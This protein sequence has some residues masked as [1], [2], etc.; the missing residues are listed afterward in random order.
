MPAVDHRDTSSIAVVGAGPAGLA[1]ALVLA[2]QGLGVSLIG[3]PANPSDTRTT[4]LLDGSLEILR[5]AG[6][7]V[8]ASG[9][10]APLRVM[11]IVDATQ[12]LIRARAVAF[13]AAEIGL[14]AFGWNIP[15]VD[16]NDLLEAA[17]SAQTGLS[18]LRT[19]VEE[20]T[21][22]PVGATLRLAEGAPLRCGLVIAADGRNSQL[23]RAAGID[24]EAKTYP[25]T[26][27][28][29]NL[30][31]ARPHD[32]RSTEFHTEEGPFTLVPLPGRRVSLVWVMSPD[33]A[34]RRASL[35]DEALAAE[36]ERQCGSMLG[37]MVID[38]P[39][40]LWPMLRQ[41][42]TSLVGP[43]LA[44]VGEAGH[45]L[46]PIGAQGLNL[47]MRDIAAL[48]AAT[49]GAVDPGSPEVLE[50][51]RRD[52]RVDVASRGT[53]VDLLNRSLLSPVLAAQGARSIGLYLLEQ[54]GPLRRAVMREGLAG[55]RR[56]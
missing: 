12:R 8:A 1:A 20:M 27:L 48:A 28:T 53:A 19:N 21:T 3:P 29:L 6:V 2:R 36:I 38:S 10:A 44:L 55:G 52:R 43:R 24:V 7:D 11:S 13:Q 33:A 15:N 51:Y 23:R 46:P 34:D 37:R 5:R 47:T 26:A 16:L 25:Q 30:R 40:S 39:R 35:D 4:A 41:S 56:A 22:D 14:E 9:K 42:A 31:T 32:D 18:R 17:V 54:A 49:A 45:T 50:A